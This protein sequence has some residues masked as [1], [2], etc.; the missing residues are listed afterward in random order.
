MFAASAVLYVRVRHG[1]TRPEFSAQLHRTSY[2]SLLGHMFDVCHQARNSHSTIRTYTIQ[3]IQLTV[4]TP[5]HHLNMFSA[6]KGL[7]KEVSVHSRP[8]ILCTTDNALSKAGVKNVITLF[9]APRSPASTR[10]YTLLKQTA[11][12]AS[13]TATEDQASSHGKEP[14]LQ[15]TAFELGTQ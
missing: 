6:F 4:T 10:V 3:K 2:V 7:F 12:N 13:A 8:S 5:R 1:S 15:R 9:H 14:K 11:G